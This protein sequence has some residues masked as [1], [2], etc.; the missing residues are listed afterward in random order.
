MAK[1]RGPCLL[2]PP[3]AACSLKKESK[4]SESCELAEAAFVQLPTEGQHYY[5]S[6]L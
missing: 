3:G 2:A 5:M 4:L 6:W 1:Y